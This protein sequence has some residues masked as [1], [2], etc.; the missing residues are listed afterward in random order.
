MA[1]GRYNIVRKLES[2]LFP[3]KMIGLL[4]FFNILEI[5]LSSEVTP[6]TESKTIKIILA[7]SRF[8]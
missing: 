3:N 2:D 6:T 1:E 5:F 4:N 7:F 8:L